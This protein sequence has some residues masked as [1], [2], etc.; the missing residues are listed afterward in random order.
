MSDITLITPPDYIYN[1]SYSFLLIYP[2]SEIKTQ[3]NNLIA[4][5]KGYINVYLYEQPEQATQHPDWLLG[6]AKQVDCIILD[7]DN[8]PSDVQ[9][10][11]S[12][13][14]ANPKTYWLT[15]GEHLYYNKLSNKRIYNLEGLLD[16][17]G[18]NFEKFRPI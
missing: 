5:I 3:F 8:C 13:F 16:S 11:T 4:N 7:I 18:G 2:N 6:I 9:Q 14:I 1:D 12:Y 10:L 17:N 15:N